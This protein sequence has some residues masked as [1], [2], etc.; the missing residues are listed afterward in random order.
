MNP[1]TKLIPTSSQTVGPFFQ[2]G[3]QYLLDRAPVMQP[4]GQFVEIHGR[5]LDRDG[6]PVPD[7]VLEFWSGEAPT[8][9]DESG[10]PANFRRAL[11]DDQGRYSAV[12][13]KS[14]RTKLEDG[15]AEAP[16]LCVLVFMRGLLRNL[17]S[18]V[19]FSNDAEIPLDLVLQ[20]VPPERRKTLIARPDGP[21]FYHWDI[22]LQGHDETVFF[23]W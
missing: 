2:I 12:V 20:E 1:T 18:R 19:Y 13:L 23:T 8:N 21:G 11:S 15:Q 7:A 6:A 3:L 22:I 16:H 17:V 4:G 14:P 9:P 5:V 10:Y